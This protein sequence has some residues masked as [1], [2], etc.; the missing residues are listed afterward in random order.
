MGLQKRTW[1]FV[2]KK[3]GDSEG[4]RLRA[5]TSKKVKPPF[6]GWGDRLSTMGFLKRNPAATPFGAQVAALNDPG[7]RGYL[8]L[9][10]F[11]PDGPHWTESHTFNTRPLQ[12]QTTAGNNRSA[13]TLSDRTA[14]GADHG[15]PSRGTFPRELS[16]SD[17]THFA[18]PCNHILRSGGGWEIG[19]GGGGCGVGSG[20]GGG[21]IG[22]GGGGCG[23]GLQF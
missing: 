21:E 1:D 7:P 22:W 3:N 5:G 13:H 14:N 19:W 16:S 12:T 18:L 2:R 23:A 15:T 20:G 6:T 4:V 17:P 10:F 9:G 8:S 11:T